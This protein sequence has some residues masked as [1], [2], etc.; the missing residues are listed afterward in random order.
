MSSYAF[1]QPDVLDRTS[2]QFLDLDVLDY[3]LGLITRAGFQNT[4]LNENTS[5]EAP[6]LS[7]HRKVSQYQI[8]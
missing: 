8:G 7:P 6:E 2:C 4:P 1:N 3:A 5:N